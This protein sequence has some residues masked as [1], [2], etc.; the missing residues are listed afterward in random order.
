MNGQFQKL[1]DEKQPSSS[2]RKQRTAEV[3][4]ENFGK[5]SIENVATVGRAPDSQITLDSRSVSR[6]HARIFYEGGH[7]WIKDLES[8]NGTTVNGKKTTLQMLDDNDKIAFGEVKAVFRTSTQNSGPAPLARDPLEGLDPAFEDGTPTGGLKGPHKPLK[9]GDPLNKEVAAPQTITFARSLEEK[10][11]VAAEA[12]GTLKAENEILKKQI[13]A[14]RTGV[15]GTR[16]H[17]DTSTSSESLLAENERLRRQ[18][19]QLER[20]LADS[21]IRLRNLQARFDQLGKSS[22]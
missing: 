11:S 4:V 5:F 7:F 19:T 3:D 10:P 14:M 15:S 9:P 21:N 17:S 8:R 13:A 12:I 2:L 6:H 18:V 1:G 20:A 16:T 22:T